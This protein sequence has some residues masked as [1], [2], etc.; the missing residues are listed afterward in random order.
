LRRW[1]SVIPVHH[2]HRQPNA[3]L[4]PSH[5]NPQHAPS[6]P[7]TTFIVSLNPICNHRTT[8]KPHLHRSAL[9]CNLF[10]VDTASAA[11]S[12]SRIVR[13]SDCHCPSVRSV[14]L[15][16]T[17]PFVHHHHP[18]SQSHHRRPLQTVRHH[19]IPV[20]HNTRPSSRILEVTI[21]FLQPPLSVVSV[22]SSRCLRP[23]VTISPI[24]FFSALSNT[25][26]QPTS[27]YLHR[28]PATELAHLPAVASTSIRFATLPS[29]HHQFQPA[30][31]SA[32][33]FPFLSS[34]RPEAIN[35]S[36]REQSTELLL[37][38][39]FVLCFLSDLTLI[40]LP[41]FVN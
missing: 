4:Q 30:F 29:Q 40:A 18:V 37:R 15:P 19:T 20:R 22:S 31:I 28:S 6:S 33:Q 16:A 9:L 41:W 5:C 12:R 1:R 27:C 36:D 32:N 11:P 2:L 21:V 35:F 24:C 3:D 10:S 8:N 17:D 14:T 7:L 23:I 13:G 39:Y 25:V 34:S 38:R 26:P